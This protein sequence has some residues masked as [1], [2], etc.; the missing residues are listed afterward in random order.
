MRSLFAAAFTVAA[1]VFASAEGIT[2]TEAFSPLAPP[3]AMAHAAYMTI[4]N[5][6]D[7]IRNLVGVAAAD[8]HM[9][10]LHQS[11]DQDGVATMAPLHQIAIEPGQSATLRP[12]QI[13]VMLMRPKKQFGTGD[14]ISLTL[15]FADGETV[16]VDAVVMGR[17]GNS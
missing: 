6:G 11:T 13:H 1:P 7:K 15:E 17:D 12:G 8:Y 16:S 2:V 10:H 9:V 14:S 5:D 3:G 4:T